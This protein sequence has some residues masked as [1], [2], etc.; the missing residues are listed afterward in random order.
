[1]AHDLE[2]IGGKASMAY[3]GD[4]PWHTLGNRL[5]KGATVD[6]MAEAGRLNWKVLKVPAGFVRDGVW[7]KVPGQFMLVRDTD[8]MFLSNCGPTYVP[9]QNHQA[10]DF[11]KRFTEAGLMSME[12]VGVLKNGKHPWALAKINDG[13]ELPG[14]DRIES[15]L[16]FSFPHEAGKAVIIKWTSIRVVCNNTA[17]Y[18]LN[19]GFDNFRMPHLQEWDETIALRAEEA[20]GLSEVTMNSFKDKAE[21]LA[22]TPITISQFQDILMDVLQPTKRVR[23]DAE[24]DMD[25]AMA[26]AK[27]KFASSQN[28]KRILEA[29][30]YSPGSDMKSAKGTAWGAFNGFTYFTDHI[31][32]NS[33]QTRIHNAWFGGEASNK[34]KVME[35]LVEFA[36]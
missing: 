34:A 11:L 26:E 5:E 12:T 18:A 8:G 9:F 7:T 10:M 16:L 27:A 3:V 31:K 24:S 15:Y 20:L 32:G 17:T 35:R 4:V 13:F 1:M 33:P 19:R 22:D 30:E 25:K 36:S 29:V 2:I 21:I 14:G 23:N 28:L 6:E